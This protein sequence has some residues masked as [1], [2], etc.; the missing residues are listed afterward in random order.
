MARINY[1]VVALFSISS[2]KINNTFC[3]L[4]NQINLNDD[5]CMIIS[6]PESFLMNALTHPRTESTLRS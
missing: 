4:A 6:S 3:P 2:E 5:V 1:I